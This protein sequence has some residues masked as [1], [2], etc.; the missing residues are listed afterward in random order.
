VYQGAVEHYQWLT[1]PQMIDGLALG[2]TKPGPLIMVV[3][4]IGFVGAWAK[5]AL[6]PELLPLA[7]I[8]GAVVATWFT[9]LPSFVFIFAGAPFIET[10][11]GNLRFTAPLAGITAAVVG[12]I[13]SLA[14]F[15]ARHTFWPQG[16]EAAP[17]VFSV[18]VAAAALAALVRLKAGLI[19]VILACGAAG[20]CYRLLFN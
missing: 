11:H 2:E 8:A 16:P 6:G 9:F 20:L 5:E 19:P 1:A 18:V 15:F 4:F 10:T 12:V 7:G 17:D 3:A 14:L 13:L